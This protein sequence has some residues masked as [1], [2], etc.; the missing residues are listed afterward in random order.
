M[1][2]FPDE[3]LQIEQVATTLLHI[4]KAS[5]DD[6]EHALAEVVPDPEYRAMFLK[7]TRNLAPTGKGFSQ[8]EVKPVSATDMRPSI[9]LPGAREAINYA[10]KKQSVPPPD[11]SAHEEVQLSRSVACSTPRPGLA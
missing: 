4:L 11:A 10:L 6:P 5:A 1:H 9:W 2:L 3:A 7:R 8:L